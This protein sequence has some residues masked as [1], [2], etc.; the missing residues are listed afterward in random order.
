MKIFY[1][2]PSQPAKPSGN[3]TSQFRVYKIFREVNVRDD[4]ITVRLR[5]L[6]H[7]TLLSTK[8]KYKSKNFDRER[9]RI[10][11]RVFLFPLLKTNQPNFHHAREIRQGLEI[12]NRKNVAQQI[13]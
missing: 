1:N 13:P 8:H 11:Q 2:P 4:T 12:S 9:D 5:S 6:R 3:E 10:L 7:G